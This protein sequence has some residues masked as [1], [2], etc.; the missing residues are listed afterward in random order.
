MC[1]CVF[2]LLLFPYLPP[3]TLCV[4]RYSIYL[5]CFQFIFIFLPCLLPCL[6][7]SPLLPSPSLSHSPSVLRLCSPRLGSAR[8]LVL[9]IFC[10]TSS[11]NLKQNSRHVKLIFI[12]FI[13]T[14]STKEQKKM[15]ENKAERTKANYMEKAEGTN[16]RRH[17]VCPDSVSLSPSQ[18]LFPF[19]SPSLLFSVCFGYIPCSETCL[20]F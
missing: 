1:W 20:H 8:W 2:P 14:T 6:L 18:T 5:V 3:S 13:F 12:Y 17:F 4:P 19:P 10:E 9:F 11:L 15:G 16:F 7:T